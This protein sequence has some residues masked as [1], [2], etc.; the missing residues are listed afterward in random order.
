MLRPRPNAL[1]AS[2]L[3]TRNHYLS[4]SYDQVLDV[5]TLNS[6]RVAFNRAYTGTKIDILRRSM[7]QL[8]L[9]EFAPECFILNPIDWED[10]E[11]TKDTQGRYIFANPQ[12][13]LGPTLWG[14]PVIVTN[15][16]TQGQF[17]TANLTQ[18]AQLWD[19]QSATVEVSREDADNFTKNMVTIRAEERVALT[20]Y[21]AT[22]LIKGVFP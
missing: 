1:V 14:R 2:D 6:L 17:L 16:M 18:A 12:S 4:G 20:V 10:I 22:A 13:L 19:R 8:Y 7:T 5:R 15:S 11:L 9:S 3:K 21:R